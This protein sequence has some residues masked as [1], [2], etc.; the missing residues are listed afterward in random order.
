MTVV[1]R[2]VFYGKVGMADQLIEQLREG[3]LIIRQSGV[4]IKPRILSDF[5]SGRTDRVVTEWEA[6]S[7]QE[8]EAAL[9]EWLAYPEGPEL[10]KKWFAR[11]TELIDY[12]DVETWQVH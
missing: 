5:L 4:A 9:T 7:F 12:A 10:V 8:L 1:Q 2:R 6:E 3:N 11:L